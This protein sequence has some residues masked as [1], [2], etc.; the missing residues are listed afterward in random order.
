[1]LSVVAPPGDHTFPAPELEEVN[2][3][4]PGAQIV[5]ADAVIVGVDGT[6]FTTTA[7]EALAVQPL[8]SVFTTV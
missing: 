2:V 3:I 1:M 5:K 7:D 4:V 6:L 8:P